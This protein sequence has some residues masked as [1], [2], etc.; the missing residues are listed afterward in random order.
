MKG[1]RMRSCI[2]ALLIAMGFLGAAQASEPGTPDQAKALV[3]RAVR[4]LQD[5]GRAKAFEDFNDPKGNFVDRDLYIFVQDM[6]ATNLAHGA[7]KALIG[8]SLYDLKDADGKLFAQEFVSVAKTSGQG[9]VDYKW[10]NPV[11]RKIEDKSTFIM[12]F[13]DMMVACGAYKS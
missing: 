12:K 13:E 5:V 9:W 2:F 11:T 6:T 1:K 7:N 4:H 10:P 3:E 8:K